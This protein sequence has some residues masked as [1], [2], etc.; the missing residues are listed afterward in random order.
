MTRKRCSLNWR[1]TLLKKNRPEIVLKGIPAAPGI[2]IGSAFLMD[3]QDFVVPERVIFDEEIPVEIARF[4]EAVSRTKQEIQVIKE[5]I[6]AQVG[7]M[8][9]QI[10]DAH[11]LVLEDCMLIDEVKKQIF[12]SNF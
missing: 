2:S 12:K 7:S 8:D 11:L 10:F 9:A 6:S 5:K 1:L 3:Q 4:E